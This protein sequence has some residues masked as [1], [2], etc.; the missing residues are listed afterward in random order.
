MAY[1]RGT[2]SVYIDGALKA[3]YSAYAPEVRR[4]IGRTWEVPYGQ[5]TIEIRSDSNTSTGTDLDAFAV[6]ISTF[7]YNTYDNTNSAIR[8]TGTSWVN[9][10]LPGAGR[11][12]VSSSNT[13]VELARLT[14]QG[15]KLVIV[16]TKR[17][18]RSNAVITIDGVNKGS[19]NMYAASDQKQYSLVYDS[20]GSGV[21]IVNITNN[22][23][24]LYIDIDYITV[25]ISFYAQIF[26]RHTIPGGF[27]GAAAIITTP[28]PPHYKGKL[29]TPMGVSNYINPE[30]HFIEAGADKDCDPP[31]TQCELHPYISYTNGS[32]IVQQTD[33]SRFL[34]AGF[35]YEYKVYLTIGNLWEAQFCDEAKVCHVLY[36]DVDIG[37]AT[38]LPF[39]I[40]GGENTYSAAIGPIAVT[41]PRYMT[42][43]SSA[44]LNWC[45]S[46][47]INNV[48]GYYSGCNSY[49][50]S[51]S[52]P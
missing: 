21:H 17:P 31:L 46:S 35:G 34:S 12:T 11:G 29:V 41:S 36:H 37:T 5:H 13:V 26:P 2:E 22:A 52:N 19:V 51:V 42:P 9:G 24:G 27:V 39:V 25:M 8:Y 10:L 4:Q 44:W 48:G 18:D 33:Y 20:L 50:W 30:L 47:V 40:T 32:S 45:P 14:F 6:D 43:S 38:A 16:Y 7:T 28:N 15:E 49:T 1:N 3:T 23:G